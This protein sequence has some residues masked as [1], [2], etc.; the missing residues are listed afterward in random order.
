MSKVYPLLLLYTSSII[1]PVAGWAQEPLEVVSI[2]EASG[3]KLTSSEINA[4]Y[5]K[6]LYLKQNNEVMIAGW[7]VINIFTC[8]P[9][10]YGRWYTTTS[11]KFGTFRSLIK[12]GVVASGPC[13]G[14]RVQFNQ[15]FYKWTKNP[16]RTR[17][18]TIVSVWQSKNH[19]SVTYLSK[20]YLEPYLQVDRSTLDKYL[21]IVLPPTSLVKISNSYAGN[22]KLKIKLE[23]SQNTSPQ[24]KRIIQV[25][26]PSNFQG[27][28]TPGNISSIVISA[29]NDGKEIAKQSFKVAN[30]GLSC[31]YTPNEQSWGKPP[32]ECRTITYNKVK[33]SGTFTNPGGLNGVFCKSFIVDLWIQ[34]SARSADGRLLKASGG[35]QSKITAYP[36]GTKNVGSDNTPVEANKTV[37]RDK[38]WQGIIPENEVYIK[39]E[40]Y[41]SALL[42]NDVGAKSTISGYRLDVYKGEGSSVCKNFTNPVVLG[43]CNK[44]LAKCPSLEKVGP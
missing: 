40:G 3:Q 25:S 4:Q 41:S 36:K 28:P 2:H 24:V 13:A 6:D 27:V 20:A 32:N 1:S 43:A 7:V 33:Y 29:T 26:S 18:D 9:V 14:Q 5:R 19:G 21:A 22:E 16:D 17:E 31:Y 23:M 44:E 42:A 30:W 15:S 38:K 12:L 11:P 35:L 37:A 8:K 10:D 34:G 39:L